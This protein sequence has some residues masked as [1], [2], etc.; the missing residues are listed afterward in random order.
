MYTRKLNEGSKPSNFFRFH[1]DMGM[2]YI[3]I[4]LKVGALKTSV[5]LGETWYVKRKNTGN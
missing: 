4:H 3:W 2:L 1:M 5:F